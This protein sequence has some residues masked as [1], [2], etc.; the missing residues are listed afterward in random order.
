MVGKIY[1]TQGFVLVFLLM[2]YA[3]SA[4]SEIALASCCEGE[5]ATCTGSASCRACKTCNY[6][7]YC[8]SGGSCGVCSGG[9]TRTSA[10]SSIYRGSETYSSPTTS[11]GNANT[12]YLLRSKEITT[13]SLNN[14]N[15]EDIYYVSDDLYSPF[16][17]KTLMVNTETL[18]LRSGPGTEY[19]VLE[20]LTKYQELIFLAMTGEWVKVKTRASNRNG[21][22]HYKFVVVLTE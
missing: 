9:S 14:Y 17:L 21:F 3:A 4:Q 11:P 16:Y 7:K 1:L 19:A 10:K 6:C 13:S 5:V 2:L 20:K 22:V 18:N 15:R 8:N 12:S